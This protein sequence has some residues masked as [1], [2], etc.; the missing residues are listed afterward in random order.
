MSKTDPEKFQPSGEKSP[1]NL[2]ESK[3]QKIRDW[4]ESEEGAQKIE[5]RFREVDE[6]EFES[7]IA[8][9]I[10]PSTLRIPNSI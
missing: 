1:F 3:L 8:G 9:R 10:Q 5:E 2:N 7:N 4:L 6:R